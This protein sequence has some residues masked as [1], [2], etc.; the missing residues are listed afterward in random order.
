MHLPGDIITLVDGCKA[1]VIEVTRV[2]ERNH[3]AFN[4]KCG[5]WHTIP[6]FLEVAKKLVHPFDR[7]DL[8]PERL[9]LALANKLTCSPGEVARRR[10]NVIKSLWQL[11]KEFASKELEA[12]N[13]LPKGI[14]GVLKDR[15]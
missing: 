10:V 11:R 5:V 14:K 3:E 13:R 15:Q 1:K 7:T 4:L 8:M 9:S 2:L 12:K 6:E